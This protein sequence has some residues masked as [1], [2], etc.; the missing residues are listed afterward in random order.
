M[1]TDAPTPYL[2]NLPE[3]AVRR[4]REQIIVID[5]LN[6]GNPE[7]LC[8]AVRACIQEKPADFRGQNLWDRGAFPGEPLCEKITWRVKQP[9]YAPRNLQEMKAR[10]QAENIIATLKRRQQE[11]RSRGG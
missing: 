10:E 11:K 2:Y 9:W 1:G 8:R 6:E 5:L 3:A 4:F 7:I